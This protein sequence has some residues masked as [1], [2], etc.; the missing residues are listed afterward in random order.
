MLWFLRYAAI[1]MN[2]LKLL[3]THVKVGE[4]F[5]SYSASFISNATVL[6]LSGND[7]FRIIGAISL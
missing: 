6:F 4:V 3:Y 2:S 1:R 5:K 7:G